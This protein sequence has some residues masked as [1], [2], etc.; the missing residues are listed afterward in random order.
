MAARI[1]AALAALGV[2]LLT[3]LTLG[4]WALVERRGRKAER[5]RAD[6]LQAGHDLRDKHADAA[7]ATRQAVEEAEAQRRADSVQQRGHRPRC[8]ARAALHALRCAVQ[9]PS[10]C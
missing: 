4:G 3:V 5:D 8:V 2:L 9:A 7:D 1:K 10:A 6:R